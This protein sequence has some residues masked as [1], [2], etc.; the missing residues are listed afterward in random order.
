MFGILLYDRGNVF[1]QS[2]K[3]KILINREAKMVLHVNERLSGKCRL[4]CCLICYN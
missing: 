4:A 2:L 1:D 3:T